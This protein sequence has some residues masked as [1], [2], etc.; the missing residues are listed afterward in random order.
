MKRLVKQSSQI[1]LI[2]ALSAAPMAVTAQTTTEDPAA[3]AAE[4]QAQG[5]SQDESKGMVT[6]APAEEQAEP[7]EGQIVMQ[8]EDSILASNLMGSSIY[9]E[10][11]ESIGKVDD[12]ILNLDGTVEG[13]VIGVG[14]FL[15]IG[16][17]SVAIEMNSLSVDQ[18]EAGNPRLDTSATKAD[19]EAAEA[20]VTKSE[21]KS[22]ERAQEMQQNTGG[23]GAG[24]VGTVGGTGAGT[25]GSAG[26]TATQ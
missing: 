16:K 19:L 13:V 10:E 25:A 7:V 15:G 23:T 22:Q 21:Q 4:G 11:G 2:A 18:D 8:S 1:A 12:M 20:F 24:A 14:G 26:G 17:K 5:T 3:S 9:S 6:D